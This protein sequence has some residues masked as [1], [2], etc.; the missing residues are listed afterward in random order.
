FVYRGSIFQ[1]MPCVITH[2]TV[3]LEKGDAAQIKATM[4]DILG[5]RKSKQPLEYPSAGSVFKRPVGYFAGGLI[6][7]CGLKGTTIGGAQVSEKHAGFIINIGGATCEDVLS[8]VKHIQDTVLRE[9]GV[10]LECEIKAI[11]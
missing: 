4:D 7:Q 10:S 1:H 11:S 2:V 3:S 8:L 9:T 6:E 5:R